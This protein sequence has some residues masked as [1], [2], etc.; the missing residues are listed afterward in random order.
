MY[1]LC[2]EPLAIL[3]EQ[4]FKQTFLT[5]TYWQALLFIY[6][7]PAKEINLIGSA[8]NANTLIAN[9]I[10]ILCKCLIGEQCSWRIV[11]G[12]LFEFMVAEL[13]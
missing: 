2:D 7:S 4:F 1:Q 9:W 6:Y 5:I 8:F 10:E 11:S 3:F 12:M 13:V